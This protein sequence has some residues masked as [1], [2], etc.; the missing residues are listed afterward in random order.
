[1]SWVKA[2]WD[3][4]FTTTDSGDGVS[5]IRADEHDPDILDV[6]HVY[7]CLRPADDDSYLTDPMGAIR[8]ARAAMEGIGVPAED[9]VIEF[10]LGEDGVG[11]ILVRGEWPD[12]VEQ[13]VSRDLHDPNDPQGTP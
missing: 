13:R 3:A 10:M 8:R 1:V 12:L 7:C 5:K 4:G 2:L 11:S 6:P 9:S